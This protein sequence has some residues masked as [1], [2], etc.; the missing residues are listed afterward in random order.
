[1][2]AADI[3]AVLFLADWRFPAS[4][5]IVQSELAQSKAGPK[6]IYG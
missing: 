6:P 5:P 2:A 3:A 1:M 4:S